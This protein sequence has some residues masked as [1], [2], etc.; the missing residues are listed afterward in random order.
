M[1]KRSTMKTKYTEANSPIYW[2]NPQQDVKDLVIDRA[3]LVTSN[4]TKSKTINGAQ[5]Y[6]N[7]QGKHQDHAGY[8]Q[9]DA[10]ENLTPEN[11]GAALYLATQTVGKII[12]EESAKHEKDTWERAGCA[13]TASIIYKKHIISCNIGDTHA[14]HVSPKEKEVYRLTRTYK[15]THQDEEE[16][17]VGKTNGVCYTPEGYHSKYLRHKDHGHGAVN[18][19]RSIG[20]KKLS[21]A[22]VG[23][24]YDTDI[25]YKKAK[26][27]DYVVLCSD[28]VLESGNNF[29]ENHILEILSIAPDNAAEIIACNQRNRSRD[30][31][32]VVV[33]PVNAAEEYPII[34]I[35][36][37]GHQNKTRLNVA[38]PIATLATELTLYATNLLLKNSG[39]KETELAEIL[40]KKV[41]AINKK[42]PRHIHLIQKFPATELTGEQQ[43]T[44][45]LIEWHRYLNTNPAP[46]CTG[47]QQMQNAFKQQQLRK[48]N[49]V[50]Y[51]EYQV[52]ID[53]AKKLLNEL[54]E[55][56]AKAL[57]KPQSRKCSFFCMR[58]RPDEVDAFYHK[59][60]QATLPSIENKLLM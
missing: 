18:M 49:G 33:M 16:R 52:D 41:N 31:R 32:G 48:D 36:A 17:I 34:G 29:H 11:I 57:K 20:D 7:Q 53:A 30:D 26:P 60:T 13:L 3:Q 27:T 56:A 24:I 42:E 8:A 22:Q 35:I 28:G 14:L 15:P 10:S 51:F 47:I 1:P 37:D 55:I 44:N 58:G 45:Q 12:L 23:L 6:I 5:L 21:D 25:T 4:D 38:N 40:K 43:L 50:S 54:Q 39:L 19:T 2:S 59:I 46:Q 9:L